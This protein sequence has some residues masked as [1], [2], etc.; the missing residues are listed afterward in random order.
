VADVIDS[1]ETQRIV[2]WA[3]YARSVAM[4]LN[5]PYEVG[6]PP[7]AASRRAIYEAASPW[8]DEGTHHDAGVT[9][10]GMVSA[11]VRAMRPGS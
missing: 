8:M 5:K 9:L 7:D 11:P 4:R 1:G 3:G 10:D 6:G 2:H